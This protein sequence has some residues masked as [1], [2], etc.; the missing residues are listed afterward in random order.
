[1]QRWLSLQDHHY[2]NKVICV[3]LCWEEGG[4]G[5][6]GGAFLEP[7][8]GGRFAS[9]FASG[10]VGS[11]SSLHS[12]GSNPSAS[13]LPCASFHAL[14]PRAPCFSPAFPEPIFEAGRFFFDCKSS[15]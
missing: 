6:G 9:R 3:R 13:F 8:L 2:A 14:L 4:A 12:C 10:R 11:C 1:M 5:K 15:P 7:V